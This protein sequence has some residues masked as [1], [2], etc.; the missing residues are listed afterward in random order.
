M[1]DRR[2]VGQLLDRAAAYHGDAIGHHQRLVL[3]VGD[4]DRSGRQL[5]QQALE[6]DLHGF[7]QL[8]VERAERFVEQQELWTDRERAR[9]RNALLLAARE[10]PHRALGEVPHV[11]EVEEAGHR[12]PDVL[13]RGASRGKPEGDVFRDG[14]VGKERVV[15]KHHAHVAAVRR[16]RRDVLTVEPHRAGVGRKQARHDAQQRGLAATGRPEQRD[17]LAALDAEVD[18]VEHPRAGKGF[19]GAGDGQEIRHS[20]LS[21]TRDQ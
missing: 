1:I 12:R 11:N 15:L 4:E 17:E 13:A 16:T 20:Q 14:E 2:R 21:V 5:A 18:A 7:A 19:R 8:A 3:V 10:H 9:D 6:L